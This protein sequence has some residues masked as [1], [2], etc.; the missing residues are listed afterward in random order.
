MR[1]DSDRLLMTRGELEALF[2]VALGGIL[3]EEIVFGEFSIGATSDLSIANR[4]AT[5]VVR[6][7]GMSKLDRKT[8]SSSPAVANYEP[9][10]DKRPAKSA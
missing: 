8:R 4:L 9:T 10:A 6:E 1:P 5:Q 7:Y 2:K 3:A